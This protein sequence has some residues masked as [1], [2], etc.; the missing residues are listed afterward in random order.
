VKLTR[1]WACQGKDVIWT[2]APPIAMQ[3]RELVENSPR[4]N[5]AATINGSA[6]ARILKR[7]MIRP[8]NDKPAKRRT[9]GWRNVNKTR[10]FRVHAPDFKISE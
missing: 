8:P 3:G 9:Y 5:T 6:E 10:Y 1:S 4:A 7:N 2:D